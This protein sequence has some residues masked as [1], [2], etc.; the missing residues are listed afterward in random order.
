MIKNRC[1]MLRKENSLLLSGNIKVCFSI[2]IVAV[3]I[4]QKETFFAIPLFS[5][6]CNIE[7]WRASIDSH[8]KLRGSGVRREQRE[9][10]KRSRGEMA[11]Q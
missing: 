3:D 5:K 8:D 11:G 9:R 10:R 2:K 6:D 7:V 4:S 1:I